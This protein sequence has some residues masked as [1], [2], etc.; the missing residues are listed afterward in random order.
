[1]RPTAHTFQRAALIRR[2]LNISPQRDFVKRKR[3]L[4]DASLD[5]S[6]R[7]SIPNKSGDTK[8]NVISITV[9]ILGRQQLQAAIVTG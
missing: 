2:L 8:M 3:R 7:P 5:A 1:M 4:S 6:D 9:L